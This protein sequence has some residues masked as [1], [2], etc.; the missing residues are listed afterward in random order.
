MHYKQKNNINIHNKKND[1]FKENILNILYT[2][3]NFLLFIVT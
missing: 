2:Y 3:L 1:K